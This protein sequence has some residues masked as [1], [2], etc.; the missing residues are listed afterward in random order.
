M[1]RTGPPYAE[2]EERFDPRHGHNGL[3]IEEEEYV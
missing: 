3:P 1:M 2:G